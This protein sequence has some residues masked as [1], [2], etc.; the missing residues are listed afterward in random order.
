MDWDWCTSLSSCW[1]PFSF[2]FLP[3]EGSLTSLAFLILFYSL[4][5]L[6][7]DWLL[8]CFLRLECVFL[9][10]SCFS[11]FFPFSSHFYERFQIQKSEII[12]VFYSNLLEG[13][14]RKGSWDWTLWCCPLTQDEC[15]TVVLPYSL[16]K[17]SNL[18]QL[19]SKVC[20]RLQHCLFQNHKSVLLP[21]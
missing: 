1:L 5:L 20:K 16:Q 14:R 10:F 21:I 6:R 18:A 17:Q 7:S 9:I 4:L 19:F 15:W 11:V 13:S 3:S 8:S 2:F 12:H